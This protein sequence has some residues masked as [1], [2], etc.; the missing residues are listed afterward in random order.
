MA[1][2]GLRCQRCGATEGLT[3]V[4]HAR[5]RCSHCGEMIYAVSGSQP[6]PQVAVSGYFCRCG[7]QV[8]S[9]CRICRQGLCRE[10]DVIEWLNSHATNKLASNP[11]DAIKPENHLIVPVERG[12]YLEA[13]HYDVKVRAITNGR[14]GPPVVPVSPI[15]PML[16]PRDIVP[17]L[18]G[19]PRDLRHV[20]VDCLMTGV[21]AALAALAE[22]RVCEYPGCGVPPA[23]NCRCCGARLCATHVLENVKATDTR[24]QVTWVK[25]GHD[26]WPHT[27]PDLV[28]V[29]GI[30]AEER[31]RMAKDLVRDLAQA[32][33]RVSPFGTEWYED[34]TS[35]GTFGKKIDAAMQELGISPATCAR[36]Q[37]FAYNAKH[38]QRHAHMQ[39]DLERWHYSSPTLYKVLT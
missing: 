16:H 29:C 30:C 26:T 32:T 3:L 31:M 21:P 9:Q 13:T 5:Y 11:L 23:T 2:A 20:C 38:V 28:G 12:G 27:G 10:C 14:I 19:G 8:E 36:E 34:K 37:W 17:H 1:F 18:S 35:F 4:D 39:A 25:R 22:G 7:A 6:Q 24:Y 33:R 15:G